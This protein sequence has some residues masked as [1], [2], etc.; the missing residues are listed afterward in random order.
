MIKIRK[1]VL[2]AMLLAAATLLPSEAFSINRPTKVFMFGFASSFNDSTVYLTD[3]QTID[4]AWID[5]R[6]NFIYGRQDFSYQFAEHLR[7]NENPYPTAIIVFAEKR[8]DIEKKFLKLRKRYTNP[9]KGVFTIKSIDTNTFRFKSIT[10]DTP[11]AT[12]TKEQL[13]AA[14]K[15]EKDDLKQKQKE[16]KKQLK[17]DQKAKKQAK[18]KAM[19]EAKQR[20]KELKNNKQ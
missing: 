14:I 6:S 12:Y 9:K 13:K 19:D 5:T 2:A 4:T 3:I 11:E 18:Q 16:A 20:A 15:K 8:K 17:T 7:S 10:P 1:K